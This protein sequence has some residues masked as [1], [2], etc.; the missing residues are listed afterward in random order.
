M[1]AQSR[2]GGSVTLP[3]RVT[4]ECSHKGQKA[5]PHYLV[6]LTQEEIALLLTLTAHSPSGVTGPKGVLCA[7]P[8]PGAVIGPGA[9]AGAGGGGDAG[10][11]AGAGAGARAPGYDE[12]IY[13]TWGWRATPVEEGDDNGLLNAKVYFKEDDYM[14]TITHYLPKGWDGDPK[15]ERVW[16]YR[17][18]G[19]E[20][21]EEGFEFYDRM[22]WDSDK[23][24]MRELQR[25]LNDA[26]Q[27]RRGF[28]DL[29]P[30][31]A[32]TDSAAGVE[33]VD[34]SDSESEDEGPAPR[35][36]KRSR[37]KLKRKYRGT[38]HMADVRQRKR[39]SSSAMEKG[40]AKGGGHQFAEGDYVYYA[41]PEE[42]PDTGKMKRSWHAAIVR[43]VTETNDP[44]YKRYRGNALVAAGQ[45]VVAIPIAD[46]SPWTE[47]VTRPSANDPNRQ[48]PG[49]VKVNDVTAPG[50]DTET[51]TE[52]G[53]ESTYLPVFDND[54]S[55]S[56]EHP[57]GF[58]IKH[59]E[60]APLMAGDPHW[61]PRL[62][63]RHEPRPNRRACRD[64]E[65][66]MG[67]P[68]MLEAYL[69]SQRIRSRAQFEAGY[70][71]DVNGRERELNADDRMAGQCVFYGRNAKEYLSDP[72]R[73]NAE[74]NEID[75][76]FRKSKRD[77]K[78]GRREDRAL[79]KAKA[80]EAKRLY[81]KAIMEQ[82]DYRQAVADREAELNE[83]DN[84]TDLDDKKNAILAKRERQE[85]QAEAAA[86]KAAI[87]TAEKDR[88]KAVTAGADDEEEGQDVDA[89]R[90]MV[91]AQ[92]IELGETQQGLSAEE[93]AAEADAD[94]ASF[95]HDDDNG[96]YSDDEDRVVGLRDLVANRRGRNTRDLFDTTVEKKKKK[97]KEKEK[98]KEKK[99]RKDVVVIDDSDDDD[100][101]DD[102]KDD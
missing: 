61:R 89:V 74:L 68:G 85:D 76:R 15:T 73:S 18:D 46:N 33:A 19:Q 99:K 95:D 50:F 86:A 12:D 59:M 87:D 57:R 94:L 30:R 42:D 51:V 27:K 93:A 96:E 32:F 71:V 20:D 102:E 78:A 2:A 11:G 49:K 17:L 92:L 1:R 65:A 63:M 54:M 88:V 29:P 9:G 5:A 8:G 25:A 48:M 22:L 58:A 44:K 52:L 28:F 31:G 13:A 26:T 80:V 45:R 16:Y 41:Y 55:G 98:E 66:A 23:N 53:T 37:L 60:A 64:L 79:R 70:K 77:V 82:E 3:R 72:T 39:G 69:D 90:A 100:G 67:G 24:D 75:R 40:K 101:D 47:T 4:A 21:E 97:K 10:A 35:K 36:R 84:I 91:K 62:L 34:D 7:P 38:L 43:E 83:I 81:D 56:D 6:Y 14:G